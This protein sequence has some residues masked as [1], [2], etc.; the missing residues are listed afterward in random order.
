M[1]SFI[2]AF[3]AAYLL[4]VSFSDEIQG[5]VSSI[6]KLVDYSYNLDFSN[7]IPGVIYN[8]SITASWAVPDSALSGLDG[9]SISVKVSASIENNNSSAY[10]QAA[11]GE[12]S[13]ASEAYLR[14]DVSNGICA[15]TSVLFAQM[16]IFVSAQPDTQETPKIALKSEIA[17]QAGSTGGGIDI[18]ASLQ[19]L[20]STNQTA[21]KPANEAGGANFLNFTGNLSESNFLDSL[22][23]NGNSNDPIEF[24]R[25]NTLISIAALA[26]VIVITGAYLLNSK[27]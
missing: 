21:A 11:S 3:L 10:F 26:I 19:G 1:T 27:D 8:G 4:S 13:S 20:L 23:P 18:I 15:N 16:P 12:K 24:L 2:G 25:Q 22:K 6:G 9:K 5:N 7:M 14:C 17:E